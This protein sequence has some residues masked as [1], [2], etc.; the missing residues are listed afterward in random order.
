MGYIDIGAQLSMLAHWMDQPP[1]SE[2]CLLQLHEECT[3]IWTT[4]VRCCFKEYITSTVEKRWMCGQADSL[5]CCGELC[6][7]QLNLPQG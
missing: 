5:L 1:N 7:F 3:W 6:V 2:H 4:G